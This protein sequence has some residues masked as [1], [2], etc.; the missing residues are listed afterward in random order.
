MDHLVA[1]GNLGLTVLAIT[2]A[3]FPM[4][5]GYYYYLVSKLVFI[6]NSNSKHCLLELFMQ[7]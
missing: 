3:Q 2:N 4:D 1:V 5:H 7:Q 6:N